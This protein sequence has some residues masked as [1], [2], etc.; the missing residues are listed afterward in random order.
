MADKPLRQLLKSDFGSSAPF[1][2]DQQKGLPYPP[3]EVVAPDGAELIDLPPLQ[4]FAELTKADL[5]SLIKGRRSCRVFDKK[6]LSLQELAFLLWSTAGV[7]EVVGENYCTLRSVPSA[8]ARHPIE[9]Y[10]AVRDVEGLESGGIYRYQPI[11]HQL[12]LVRKEENLA[13]LASAAA[14]QQRFVG[15]AAVTFYWVCVPYRSEWRYGPHSY[16]VDLLDGGHIA[17]NLYLAAEAIGCGTC[18]IAAYD[19]K[20]CDSLLGVDG[21]DMFTIYLSPVGKKKVKK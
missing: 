3:L 1:I 18:A 12:F 16:K 14:L 17:Q 20:E 10:I 6:G 4:D 8:G 13:E 5:F 2:S 19:Q 9:T 15:R 11:E 21:E 7:H